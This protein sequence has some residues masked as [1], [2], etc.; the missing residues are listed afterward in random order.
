MEFS[1]GLGPESLRVGYR[2]LI[3]G[4]VVGQGGLGGHMRRRGDFAGFLQKVVNLS[5]LNHKSVPRNGDGVGGVQFLAIVAG[6]PNGRRR[7]SAAGMNNAGGGR[8]IAGGRVLQGQGGQAQARQILVLLGGKAAD[9][10]GAQHQVGG[11]VAHHHGA[12]HGHQLG[13]AEVGD[14]AVFVLKAAGVG[15]GGP[16]R[17]LRR[18]KPC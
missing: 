10:D 7:L 4:V 3:D 9:A 8:G 12:L 15:V 11:R 13:V 16:G 6:M 2:A 18:C 5:L 17:T 14:A 1:G